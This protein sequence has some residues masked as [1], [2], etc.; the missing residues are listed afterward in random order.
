MYRCETNFCTLYN[1][2]VCC[3]FCPRR[4]ECV[5]KC[6]KLFENCGKAIR[7]ERIIFKPKELP[8]VKH[9]RKKYVGKR[10]YRT[11]KSR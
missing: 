4:K 1:E 8:K 9:R 10:F 11:D 5:F 2:K 7:D 6:K 3:N